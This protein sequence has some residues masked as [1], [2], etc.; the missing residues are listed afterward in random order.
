M[1][2]DKLLV[3]VFV[4]GVLRCL[5][6][7]MIWGQQYVMA[8]DSIPIQTNAFESFKMADSADE[9]FTVFF[10][11]NDRYMTTSPYDWQEEANEGLSFSMKSQDSV[12]AR[13]FRLVQ[14]QLFYDMGDYERSL[15]ITK[16]L[17]AELDSTAN[18]YNH[19]LFGLMDDNY[20]QLTMYDKQIEVRKEMVDLGLIDS[21]V[22]YDIYSNLGRH[23]KAMEDYIAREGKN[24]SETE[25]YKLAEYHNHLGNYLRLDKS[26]PTAITQYKKAAGYVQ[27]YLN[28]ITQDK[29]VNQMHKTKL[30]KSLI[31][32]NIGKSEVRLGQYERAMP[33]LD[34]SIVNLKRL[35]PISMS[36]EIVENT[37]ALIE[38]HL[39]VED[40]ETTTDLLLGG[41]PLHLNTKNQ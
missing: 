28:D 18:T 25:F 12:A 40:F 19:L 24:I 22:L 6:F 11:S 9:K 32:G 33:K 21:Y 15:A 17:S 38:C 14:S 36:S 37:L 16:E 31:E 30:L 26:Y 13:Q 3:G 1:M 27:V 7:L 41:L 34:S 35:D 4:R 8:Q 39:Q 5:P 20:G 23:R 2:L 29:D 10:G